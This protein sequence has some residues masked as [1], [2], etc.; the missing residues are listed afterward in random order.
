MMCAARQTS[1]ERKSDTVRRLTRSGEYKK[2][3]RIA[4]GFRLGITREQSDKMGIAYECM[5][6]PQFYEQL[7]FVIDEKI[8][9][10]V[11]VLVGLYGGE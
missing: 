1:R 5:V 11:K 8:D 7:G 9:D 2:A 6:H 10:G 4:K 3:L